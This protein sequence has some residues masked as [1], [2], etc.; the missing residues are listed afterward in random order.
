MK[1]AQHL[2]TYTLRLCRKAMLLVRAFTLPN[3]VRVSTCGTV[4]GKAT[5]L[6]T[7]SSNSTSAKLEM[8]LNTYTRA[9]RHG[10]CVCARE[11]DTYIVTYAG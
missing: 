2:T 11:R 8:S 6:F 10:A 4:F 7:K 9:D 3:S 5:W 1:Y